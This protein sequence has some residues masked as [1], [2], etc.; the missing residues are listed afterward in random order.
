MRNPLKKAGPVLKNLAERRER[1]V[2]RSGEQRQLV[3]AAARA[4][5]QKLVL[6]N[7]ATAFLQR[8]GWRPVMLGGALVASLAIGP[9]RAMTWATR[10]SALYSAF[11]QARR[12]FGTQP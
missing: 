4:A 3:S 6:A 7:V 9:R 11:R 1:L 2:R 10:A 12:L 8:I 5:A